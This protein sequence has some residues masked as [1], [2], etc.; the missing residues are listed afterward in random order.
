MILNEEQNMLKDAAR[1]FCKNNMPISQL[2][3]L[4]DDN[5]ANGFDRD[6]WKSMADLGWAADL[7][8][9]F[10]VGWRISGGF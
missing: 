1:E 2:R 9:L 8:R 7:R 3:R 4:R 6:S 5:D 10:G